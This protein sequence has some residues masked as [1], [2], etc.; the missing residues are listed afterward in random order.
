[1]AMTDEFRS[2]KTCAYCYIQVRLAKARRI[3]KEKK[4][5]RTVNLNGAV[6]CINPNCASFQ[7]GYTVKPRDS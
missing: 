5:I 2:S 6:E 4:P 7:C 1:M 3:D